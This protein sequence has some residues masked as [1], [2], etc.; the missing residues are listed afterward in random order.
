MSVQTAPVINKNSLNTAMQIPRSKDIFYELFC[1]IF[2]YL[3]SVQCADGVR[4]T[5]S[6]IEVKTVVSLATMGEL[7]LCVL[8]TSTYHTITYIGQE[9]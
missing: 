5:K 2:G 6:T 8:L 1:R 3:A 4:N 7:E 9:Y